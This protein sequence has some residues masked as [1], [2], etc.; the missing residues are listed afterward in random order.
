[1]QE[2]ETIGIRAFGDSVSAFI[3]KASLGVK[4]LISDRGKIVAELRKAGSAENGESS[5][6]N[7]WESKGKIIAGNKSKF[8]FPRGNP[9]LK[10]ISTQEILDEQRSDR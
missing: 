9:I 6:L 7:L 3:R 4:I 5:L 10:D 8:K 1:M 2:I